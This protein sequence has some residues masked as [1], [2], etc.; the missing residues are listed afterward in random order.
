MSSRSRRKEDLRK[1]DLRIGGYYEDIALMKTLKQLIEE[2]YTLEPDI[3]EL[4]RLIFKHKTF[5]N[6][7]LKAKL[8]YKSLQDIYKDIRKNISIIWPPDLNLFNANQTPELLAS[9]QNLDHLG[10]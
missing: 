6:S 3:Q 7:L 1:E 2:I 5:N 4:C 9:R 10:K 8:L